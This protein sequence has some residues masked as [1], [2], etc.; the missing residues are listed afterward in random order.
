M[1]RIFAAA[2]LTGAALGAAAAPYA[3]QEFDFSGLDVSD[4]S[5]GVVE[6][7]N[8]GPRTGPIHTDVF[9]HSVKPDAPA[10][11]LI[12]LDSGTGVTLV[13]YGPERF[14]PGQRV[15]LVRDAGGLRAEPAGLQP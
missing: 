14:R 7:V 1:K 13:Q 3:P 11:L 15:Q 5:Y 6:T 10:D 2:I 12:R 8:P 4:G 9:E